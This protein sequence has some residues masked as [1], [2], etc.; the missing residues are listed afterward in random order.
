VSHLEAEDAD[1][2]G[3]DEGEDFAGPQ[4]DD[5]V[6]DSD[7]PDTE[8]CPYCG[9]SIYEHAEFCPHC[10]KYISTEDAPARKSLWIVIGVVIA[11]A[12]ILC[13]VL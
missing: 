9:R 4:E 6:E 13:W 8:P 1:D 7:P 10:G 3:D 11:L 5:V 2:A 12:A